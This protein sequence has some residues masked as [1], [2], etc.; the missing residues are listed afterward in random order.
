MG[1]LTRAT[2][3][4]HHGG[5]HD[6][7]T[8]AP[9]HTLRRRRCRRRLRASERFLPRSAKTVALPVRSAFHRWIPSALA[10]LALDDDLS[11]RHCCLGFAASTQLPPRVHPLARARPGCLAG[12]SPEH[13]KATWCPSASAVVWNQGHDQEPSDSAM[14]RRRTCDATDDVPSCEG[15]QPNPLSSG[16]VETMFLRPPPRRPTAP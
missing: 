13:P 1:R 12:Y 5:R 15:H 11:G 10:E 7:T 9:R 2:V 16:A 14:H 8:D 4:H 3:V 6:P